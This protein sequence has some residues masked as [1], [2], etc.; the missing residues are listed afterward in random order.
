MALDLGFNDL[1]ELLFVILVYFPSSAIASIIASQIKQCYGRLI[2][3]GIIILFALFIDSPLLAIAGLIIL[4]IGIADA[5]A[6][7]NTTF[8]WLDPSLANSSGGG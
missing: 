5:I 7:T 4:V 2:Q 6:Q 8:K 1:L 3:G